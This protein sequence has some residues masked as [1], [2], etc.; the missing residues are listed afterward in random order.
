MW[1]MGP[2]QGR[3]ISSAVFNVMINDIFSKVGNGFGFSL[4]A[5][6]GTV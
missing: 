3:V 1:T 4:F 2:H 5:D 6:D